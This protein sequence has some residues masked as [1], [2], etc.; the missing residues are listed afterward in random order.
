MTITRLLTRPH[1]E[2]AV[3]IQFFRSAV[4]STCLLVMHRTK[5]TAWSVADMRCVGD[6][7]ADCVCGDKSRVV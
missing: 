1:T 2:G 5:I 7:V 3:F 4:Y 6:R